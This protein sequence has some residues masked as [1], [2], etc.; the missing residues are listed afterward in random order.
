MN[1]SVACVGCGTP[2]STRAGRL[3]LAATDEN[4][5]QSREQTDEI[6]LDHTPSLLTRPWPVVQCSYLSKRLRKCL[7]IISK[8]RVVSLKV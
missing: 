2:S 7:V 5:S 8:E 1:A 3:R 4:E 6:K